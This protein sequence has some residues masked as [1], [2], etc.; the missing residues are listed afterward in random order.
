MLP[1]ISSIRNFQEHL[2]QKWFQEKHK[3]VLQQ[4]Q[5]LSTPFFPKSITTE[6]LSP[7]TG[8]A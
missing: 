5:Q 2:T 4:P 8:V 7:K 3:E 1:S 6:N